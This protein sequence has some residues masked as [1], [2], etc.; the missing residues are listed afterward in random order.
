MRMPGPLRAV[1]AVC[2]GNLSFLFGDKAHSSVACISE[3]IRIKNRGTLYWSSR[4]HARCI[5]AH[6]C[7]EEG[8]GLT[9]LTMPCRF[10]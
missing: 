8:V 1:L 5:H 6:A 7:I 2:V 9:T 3:E 4:T 10:R